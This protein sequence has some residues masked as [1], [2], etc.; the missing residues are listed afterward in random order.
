MLPIFTGL[1][2]G[3][4]TQILEQIHLEFQQFDS[5]EVIATQGDRCDRLTYVLSGRIM[6]EY[7]DKE[8]RFT[9]KEILE[10]PFI[11]E[12]F[13]FYGLTQNYE[14][15]YV[16]EER[17]YTF[18]M[19]KQEFQN[20]MLNYKIT[21]A[22]TLNML[23]AKVQKQERLLKEEEAGSV[24][25]KIMQFLL[26]HTLTNYGEKNLLMKMEDMAEYIKE[27]RLNVS[28]ALKRW[29]TLGLIEQS[30]RGMV[31]IPDF[32]KLHTSVVQSKS[33]YLNK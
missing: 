8:H 15:S 20:I 5:G 18:A 29:S 7:V 12:P 25:G 1:T 2:T 19:S 27:T 9:L 10:K 31:H 3:E 26:R 17:T 11:I 23:C 24:E 14:R 32:S 30:R 6:A 33:A 4:L 28:F 21:R 22:N 16:T 13:R